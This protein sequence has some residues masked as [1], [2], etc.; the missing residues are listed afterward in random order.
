[1]PHLRSS[2]EPFRDSRFELLGITERLGVFCPGGFR[3]RNAL[4]FYLGGK[5]E[6]NRRPSRLGCTKNKNPRLSSG[7]LSLTNT[8][9]KCWME[10]F[11]R[12]NPNTLA[13]SCRMNIGA[14]FNIDS[15]VVDT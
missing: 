1:M 2:A 6:H 8:F 14:V 10:V 15:Y 4:P 5:A 9:C 11:H 7:V 13:A 3:I 12:L